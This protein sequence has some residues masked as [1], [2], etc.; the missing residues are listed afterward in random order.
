M[1]WRSAHDLLDAPHEQPIAGGQPPL[2]P[3]DAWLHVP[4][5][6]D[7]MEAAARVKPRRHISPLPAKDT[8]LR[9]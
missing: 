1:P 4:V 6:R 5:R 7:G 9:P 8:S 2:D 3:W